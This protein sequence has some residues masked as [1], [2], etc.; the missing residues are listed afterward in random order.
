MTLTVAADSAL[1]GSIDMGSPRQRGQKELKPMLLSPREWTHVVERMRLTPQ[2]TKIV[3]LILRGARDKQ[4]AR[5]L[6]LRAPTIR[7]HLRAIFQ[8]HGLYDRV[9]LVLQCFSVARDGT[10]AE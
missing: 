2:Q 4:I 3:E 10:A 9:E 7:T 8:K 5:M 6:G 1:K